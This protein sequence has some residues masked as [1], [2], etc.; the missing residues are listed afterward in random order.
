MICCRFGL[1]ALSLT[2]LTVA[3]AEKDPFTPAQRK[4][5]AFQ[6]VT[7]PAL[8]K[9]TTNPIDAF[10]L[11]KLEAKHIEP[12]APA[13]KITLLRRVSFDLIG[14]PPTPEEVDAFVAD[15]SPNAYE[16]VVDRLLASP[17]YGER[18]ARHWLDLARYAESEG[19]KADETRPNAWRYR[20][21]VVRAF[22][23]NKPYDRFVR[24][25]IA[26][27][28]LWPNDPWARVATGFNRHY[29]DESNARVLQQ[30]RQEILNDITDTVGATFMG[31]TY[32]CARCHTHKFDPILHTDYYSL[33]AF[34]ANTAADDAIPMMSAAELKAFQA[35]KAVWEEKT[36]PIREEIA[37]LLEPQK[38]ALIKEYVDKYPPEIQAI[39]AKPGEQRTAFEWQ[40]YAKAKPYIEFDDK[41]A[42]KGLKGADKKKYEELAAQLNQFA[43]IDPGELPVGIGMHDLNA[44]APATH[45][46]AVGAWD[47]P[48]EE[49]QPGFLSIIDASAP[50]IV[51][52]ANSSGRR[53]ALANWLASPE[54]PLSAR[55]M[56]NR[57]WSYH[58]DEGL[59][60]AP[61]DF[62]LM[63][64]RP[65]NSELLDWLASEFVRTGWD[66]KKMN[67]L[68]VMS[69]TYRESSAFNAKAAEEDPHNK[70][71]WRFPRTRLDGE[72]I[73]DSALM[74]SG[75]LNEKVGGPSVYPELPSGAG[76]PRGGWKTSTGDDRNRRSVYVFVRRN[77]RYPMLEAFDMP[78]THESC[79][80]RNQ[81]ITAPQAMSLLNSKVSLDWAEAFAGRVLKQAGTD[82]KAQVETAY[83]L[84]YGRRP[85]G[86]EK[87]SVMTFLEKQKSLISAKQGKMA[88]P[89]AMPEGYDANQA[90]ALVDLCQMLINSN[91]FVFRN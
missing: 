1:I 51:P 11:A 33:Q 64:G 68:M 29:P 72:V 78:D 59:A 23:E 10:I 45:V 62:G 76:T 84:A 53:T 70:L 61:S 19:F 66:I 6:P 75:L 46:L 34:F 44:Q 35:K 5:W 22:N 39:L 24:E 15:Q 31:M 36:A 18:W 3:G 71:L 7:R 52:L 40:M 85:D 69:N 25:Q 63:G 55:V 26:G 50:K 56:V 67:K 49:V 47:A 80:R 17:H 20:D 8:P 82:P 54:N 90:A 81:T 41:T 27:D 30:R 57:L 65:S 88:L 37:A 77:A 12:A 4:Y 21:Y 43:S 38:K 9:P 2:A 83:R 14:L 91:E 89:V 16:K 74:V 13:D 28:E 58:F 60:P 32:A 48:K 87:D 42:A 73:R 79:G 86:F